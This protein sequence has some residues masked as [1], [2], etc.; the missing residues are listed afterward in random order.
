MIKQFLPLFRIALRHHFYADQTGTGLLLSPSPLTL[1]HM[2]RYDLHWRADGSDYI[3]YYGEEEGKAAALT[4]MEQ[5]AVLRFFLRSEHPFFFNI[6]DVP[7]PKSALEKFHLHNLRPQPDSGQPLSLAKGD[8]VG[9]ED[10]ISTDIGLRPADLG[11]VD[12]HFAGMSNNKPI[13]AP[14]TGADG[15][16]PP[17]HLYRISFNARETHWRYFVVNRNLPDLE[18]MEVIAEGKIFNKGKDDHSPAK[19]EAC[20]IFDHGA[21][22]TLRTLGQTAVPISSKCAFPLREYPDLKPKLKIVRKNENGNTGNGLITTVDLPT[23]DWRR[24]TP[25]REGSDQRVF[26]DMYVYL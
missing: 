20:K 19:P 8:T 12:I 9:S 13:P 10:V 7:F 18:S 3:M 23:P 11:V 4:Y 26:S 24:V 21:P 22:R 1:Q 17:E 5:A 16:L 2:R 6:T 15:S 14:A 25:E